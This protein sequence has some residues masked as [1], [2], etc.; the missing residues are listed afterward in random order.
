MQ[1]F[2]IREIVKV[3]KL[4]NSKTQTETVSRYYVFFYFFFSF[5]LHNNLERAVSYG[6]KV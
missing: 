5:N 1:N 2:R 4:S 3:G 6:L